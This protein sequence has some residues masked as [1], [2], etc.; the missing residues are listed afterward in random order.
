MS[1]SIFTEHVFAEKFG[2]TQNHSLVTKSNQNLI[3][4]LS[5]RLKISVA[6][7]QSTSY[8]FKANLRTF[9]DKTFSILFF[10]R[11]FSSD[12]DRNDKGK[13]IFFLNRHLNYHLGRK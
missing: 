5:H 3:I 10:F 11:E 8:L 4:S 6:H 7:C 13:K 9:T 1:V 12:N 2:E